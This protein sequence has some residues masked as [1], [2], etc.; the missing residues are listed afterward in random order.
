VAKV[1]VE[2]PT[3]FLAGLLMEQAS[4]PHPTRRKADSLPGRIY[5]VMALTSLMT[6]GTLVTA[7]QLLFSQQLFA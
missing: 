6:F 7:Y 3:D 2:V 5:V 4:A 1:E